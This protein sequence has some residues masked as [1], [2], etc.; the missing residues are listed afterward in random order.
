MHSS[1]CIRVARPVLAALLFTFVWQ[2]CHADPADGVYVCDRDNDCPPHQGCDTTA[3]LCFK[4]IART[5]TESGE[6]ACSQVCPE[7]TPVCD[8][9]QCVECA[10]G[11]ARCEGDS[12]VLCEDGHW[13]KQPA[14][15]GET[16]ACS[17]G[18]CS[19]VRLIGSIVQT[20]GDLHTSEIRLVDARLD[21]P[22][23]SC[24]SVKGE[25]TCVVGA[26]SVSR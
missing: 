17:D 16:V 7:A 11:S 19:S 26:L 15:G 6:S 2:A 22:S 3:H 24:G 1:P 21:G 23:M 18:V 9:G 20:A 12:P 5:G 10:P 4:H 13:Q 14:C 8:N 25:R